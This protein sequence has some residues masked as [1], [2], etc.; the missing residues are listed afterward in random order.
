ML[1]SIS[2]YC[3]LFINYGV[4]TLGNIHGYHISPQII[5]KWDMTSVKSVRKVF[6]KGA[7]L[8]RSGELCG[9]F[10]QLIKLFC[11]K[12]IPEIVPAYGVKKNRGRGMNEYLRQRKLTKQERLVV[13]KI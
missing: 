2:E 6:Q 3:I 7:E 13:Y 9:P 12:N 8:F 5:W 1:T 4:S 10:I 11:T